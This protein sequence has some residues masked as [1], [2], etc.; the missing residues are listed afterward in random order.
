MGAGDKI[1]IKRIENLMANQKFVIAILQRVKP[2]RI[3]THIS[4]LK[5]V[6][7]LVDFNS[8]ADFLHY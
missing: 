2:S 4:R 7:C 6:Q 3:R 1:G 8:T 5:H